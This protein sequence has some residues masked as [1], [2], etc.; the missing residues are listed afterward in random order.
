MTD[1]DLDHIKGQLT[2]I[3]QD[4]AKLRV[5]VENLAMRQ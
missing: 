1:Q 3:R 5:I 4:L 2:K